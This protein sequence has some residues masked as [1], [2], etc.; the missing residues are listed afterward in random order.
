MSD[1]QLSAL[2]SSLCKNIDDDLSDFEWLNKISQE[3]KLRPSYIAL[4]FLAVVLFFTMIG[5]LAHLFVTIFGMPYPSY[6]S[7]KVS[8]TLDRPSRL[9]MCPNRKNGSPIGS[10]L[11]F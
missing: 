1:N 6:M 3:T 7:F 9:K 4:G 11:D 5:Y 2:V 8:V 10:C